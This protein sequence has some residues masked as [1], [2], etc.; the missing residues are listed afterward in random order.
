VSFAFEL[1]NDVSIELATAPGRALDLG[2]GCGV[3]GIAMT[4]LGYATEPL[5]ASDLSPEAV[6]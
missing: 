4:K 1:D 5:F 3:V 2:C 6:T